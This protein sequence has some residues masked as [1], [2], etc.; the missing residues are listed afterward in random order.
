[1]FVLSSVCSVVASACN[2]GLR[3]LAQTPAFSP[4]A[5]PQTPNPH[6]VW[7]GL[8]RSLG[9]LCHVNVAQI[10]GVWVLHGAWSRWLVDTTASKATTTT[11]KRATT[12]NQQQWTTAT[13]GNQVKLAIRDQLRMYLRQL[14]A[15]ACSALTSGTTQVVT[16]PDSDLGD[17]GLNMRLHGVTE[18]FDTLLER[19]PHLAHLWGELRV[20]DILQS[21][22]AAAA[23]TDVLVFFMIAL[24]KDPHNHWLKMAGASLCSWVGGAMTAVLYSARPAGD[25]AVAPPSL[26]R[27]STKK[28]RRVDPSAAWAV[29]Q[30]ARVKGKTPYCILDNDND[31]PELHQLHPSV[32]TKWSCHPNHPA[33]NE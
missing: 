23:M 28:C 20:Q 27:G 10:Q 1:M 30:K 21:H 22:P 14:V 3:P 9:S 4:C 25:T 11:N 7:H 13:S 15:V 32:A 26:L 24:G 18:Q 8:L 2:H 6:T 5:C 33:A 19:R 17:F 29:L 16:I 31:R 12:A